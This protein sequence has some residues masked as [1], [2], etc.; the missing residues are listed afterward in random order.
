MQL[1]PKIK[2]NRRGF[3]LRKEVKDE[4][5]GVYN[6]DIIADVKENGYS[7]TYGRVTVHLAK[8]FGFC[9]GVDRAVELAYETCHFHQGKK[10]YLT[11]EIIHNPLVNQ[12]LAE[13]GVQFLSGPYKNS[14]SEDITKDDIVI[15]P[16][17]GAPIDE[18]RDLHNIGCTLVDTICGSV[19]NVWKRVEKYAEEG[20]TSIIH[21][22][23]YHE[24]TLATSAQVL[25]YP[26]GQYLIVFDNDEAQY[27]CD[28]I[29]HGGNKEEFLEKFKLAISPG[30]D[31]DKHLKSVGLANQTTMLSSESLFI[32]DMIKKAL[33]E[34]NG[35]DKIDAHFRS[36]D[37]ICSATQER[38]DAI[39]DMKDLKPDL[40]VV[41]GG[42]NSSNTSNLFRI[43]RQYSQ[44]YHID[45]AE[46]IQDGKTLRHKPFG[47]KEEV[48]AKDWLP[49]GDFSIGITAGASTPNNVMGEVLNKV[50]HLAK[51]N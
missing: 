35:A 15:V 6:S 51:T 5:Q 9:Y 4:I 13:M 1:A 22:K 10:I 11:A 21:G 49:K 39:I 27:V 45:R 36:F 24:E 30:F 38:Q 7:K 14:K 26:G 3:G 16:A 50:I 12:N 37:T 25:Q 48:I 32:A 17:F 40:T 47:E 42:Y 34:K 43:S 19:I 31:P 29:L 46:C 44:S 20:F 18:L 41:I 8:E 33:I 23:Y 2:M 28:Y